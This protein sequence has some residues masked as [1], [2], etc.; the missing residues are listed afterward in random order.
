MEITISVRSGGGG[1]NTKKEA[2][3]LKLLLN[4]V[5]THEH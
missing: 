4:A 3:Q 1:K 2:Q 5:I